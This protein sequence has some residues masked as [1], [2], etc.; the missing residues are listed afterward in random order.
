LHNLHILSNIYL[1]TKAE[2]SNK[3]HSIAVREN[4]VHS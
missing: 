1:T 3:Q 4:T 2:I